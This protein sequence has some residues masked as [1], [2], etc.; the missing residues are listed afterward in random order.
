MCGLFYMW[1]WEFEKFLSQYADVDD[2]V[3]GLPFQNDFHPG[4]LAAVVD[5]KGGKP[6]VCV[7]RWGYPGIQGKGVIFNARSETVL[8]KRLFQ[9]GIQHHRCVIPV[10]GFYEWNAYKQKY[11][12]YDANNPILYLAGFY[13]DWDGEERFVILTRAANSTVSPIHHRMPVMLSQEQIDMWLFG[14]DTYQI[15]MQEVPT[16]LCRDT[17]REQLTLF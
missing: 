14:K 11:R 10:S 1:E 17:E 9:R 15:W 12:F 3:K 2:L 6:H 16:N 7:K 8:E 13:D 4:Q 5:G